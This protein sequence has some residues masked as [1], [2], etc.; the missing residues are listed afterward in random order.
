MGKV[1]GYWLNEQTYNCWDP[2]TGQLQSVVI[3]MPRPNFYERNELDELEHYARE[4][5]GKDFEE[6]LANPT[7]KMS[8]SQQNQLGKTLM[9]IRTSKQYAR[10]NSGHGRYW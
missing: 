2:D 6:A 3:P 5:A 8:K 10:E 1:V 7:P 4:S 9:E